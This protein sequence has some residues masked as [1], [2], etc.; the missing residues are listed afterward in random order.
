MKKTNKT[1]LVEATLKIILDL[2]IVALMF[3]TG[4]SVPLQEKRLPVKV[5]ILPK[6]EVGEIS[7]DFPGEAQYFYD[8]YFRNG[9]E[10]E[11]DGSEG[12]NKIYY[13]DGVAMCTVGQ[14]KV[15]AALN[16][17]AVLTDKRFDFSD[18]YILS[19]GCGG[20]AKDY[21]RFGDVYVISSVVDYDLGHWADSRELKSKDAATWFHDKSYDGHAVV[22]LDKNLTERAFAQ[23]EKV[24]LDTTAKTENFLQKEYFGEEWANRQPKVMKGTSMTADRYWKGIYDHQNALLMAKTYECED[25]YAMTEME[26]IAVAQAVKRCGMQDRLI[27]LRVAVNIDVFPSD[28]TPEM[29]WAPETDDH[30]ASSG[31]LESV[32]IFETGMKNCFV[33]GKVLVDSIRKGSLK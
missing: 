32:D 24:K 1:P 22:K 19:V 23:I 12:T 2:L 18:A 10:Y 15:N 30:V 7:G 5:L 27:I 16:T 31:S 20:A 9:E 29:L 11:I 8:E 26:D 17:T 13:K 21:G 25:P 3:L 4:C 33:T 28:T 6:F 14:G